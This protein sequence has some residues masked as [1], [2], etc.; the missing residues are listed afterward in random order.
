MKITGTNKQS[1]VNQI[2]D[3]EK[4]GYKVIETLATKFDGYLYFV[5]E[6]EKI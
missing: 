5:C 4:Q 2:S 6:M 1:F 3:F